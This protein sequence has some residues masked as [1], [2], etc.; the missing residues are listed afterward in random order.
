MVLDGLVDSISFTGFCQAFLAAAL[1][2][3]DLIVLDNL[4]SH[5][6]MAVHQAV[7]ATGER[8]LY[9]PPYSPDLNP[10]EN[11]FSKLKQLLRGLRPQNW[12]EIIEATK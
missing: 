7:E 2:P 5:K 10:I 8:L 1:Q 6:S 12:N 11:I 9:L 3:G 4:S